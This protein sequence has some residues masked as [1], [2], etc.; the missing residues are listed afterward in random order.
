MWWVSGYERVSICNQP[1][2]KVISN[3]RYFAV[4][5]HEEL[6][7]KTFESWGVDYLKLD[8][9]NVFPPTEKDYQD[10][11]HK[12]HEILTSLERPLVFSE[13]APAYFSDT[14]NNTDWYRVMDW[15]PVYGV[16]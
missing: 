2:L 1:T 9:C 11:Y 8:G 10:I 12:W 16:S 6:D 5:S 15:V 13:S 7:A 14:N 3:N 4:H